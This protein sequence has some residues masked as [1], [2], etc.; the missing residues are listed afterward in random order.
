MP[1]RI[2]K[3]MKDSRLFQEKIKSKI[4]VLLGEMDDVVPNEWG[5]KFAK[6]QD[7]TVE[8]LEDDHSF[9]RNMNRLPD[10]ITNI[11]EEKH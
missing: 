5:L 7:A 4:F 8:F 10:I 6:F 3:D 9:T 11:L 1:Q 2:L